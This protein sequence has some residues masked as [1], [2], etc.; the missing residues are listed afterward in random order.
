MS[1]D[2]DEWDHYERPTAIHDSTLV[3]FIRKIGPS[4]SS[5]IRS[6]ELK[7]DDTDYSTTDILRA[8]QLAAYHLPGLE[9]LKLLYLRERHSLE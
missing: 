6:L 3:A 8:T 4:K 7:C 5:M 2:E 1:Y 9:T